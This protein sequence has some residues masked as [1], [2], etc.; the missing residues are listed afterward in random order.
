MTINVYKIRL[1]VNFFSEILITLIRG[2]GEGEE[3]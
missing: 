1:K 2:G 3:K